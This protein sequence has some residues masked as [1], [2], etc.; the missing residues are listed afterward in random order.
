MLFIYKISNLNDGLVLVFA[1]EGAYKDSDGGNGYL[2]E[3][4]TAYTIDSAIIISN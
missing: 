2:L 4:S 1:K 3:V